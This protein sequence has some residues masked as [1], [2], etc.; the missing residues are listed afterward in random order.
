MSI[1]R[2]EGDTYAIKT[3]LM[4][5]DDATSQARQFP[6]DWVHDNG[7]TLRHQYYK[8]ASAF[9]VGE[10]ELPYDGGLPCF[11]RLNK[12]KVERKLEAYAAT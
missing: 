7:L 9:I 12:R 6:Q 11:V 5:F 2:A 10:V 8:Y 3:G 1:Q 4:S